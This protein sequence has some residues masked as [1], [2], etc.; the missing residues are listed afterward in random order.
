MDRR[1]LVLESRMPEVLVHLIRREGW[2]PVCVPA[3]VEADADPEEVRKPL[4]RLCV[5]GVDWV[6]LQTGTGAERLHRLADRLGLGQ[7]YLEALRAVPI[8]VRGPKPT[9]VLRRWGIHPSL[10][11]PSPYTTAELCATLDTVELQ[12][13]V[14]FVQHYGEVNE[15]LRNHLTGRGTEVVDVQPY[16]WVLPADL[17]PLQEAVRGLV[18]GAFWAAVVTSRP[19]VIH[20]FRVA[21]EMGWAEALREALQGRVTVAA[22]GPVS[23]QALVARGVRVGVEPEHPKMGRLIEALRRYRREG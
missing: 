16:R 11:A 10:S 13:R 6:V 8:A 7:A 2:E 5:R 21:E 22:V 15:A 12:N 1:V 17:R 18:E 3:V 9:A 23:R 19:Q 14:V 20:L 4:E